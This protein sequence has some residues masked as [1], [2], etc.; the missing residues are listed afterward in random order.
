M[1]RNGRD[2]L[3]EVESTEDVPLP[4]ALRGGDGGG[5]RGAVGDEESRRRGIC[6]MSETP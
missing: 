3:A 4:D 5:E 6:P 2:T 1:E